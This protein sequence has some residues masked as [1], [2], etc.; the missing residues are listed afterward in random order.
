MRE[1]G[2]RCGER[3]AG[4]SVIC[5][6]ANMRRTAGCYAMVGGRS[7]VVWKERMTRGDSRHQKLKT[8]K[9]HTFQAAKKAAEQFISGAAVCRR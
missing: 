5:T 2:L 7:F 8:G 6:P 4:K 3:A 1:V 9:A